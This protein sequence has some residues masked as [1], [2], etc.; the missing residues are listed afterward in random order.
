[1]GKRDP[2]TK[3]GKI[4]KGTNGVSRP[5]RGAETGWHSGLRSSAEVPPI[6]P[7]PPGRTKTS[8]AAN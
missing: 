5:A 1:M 4:F 3:K 7:P 8:P 6:P 2:R